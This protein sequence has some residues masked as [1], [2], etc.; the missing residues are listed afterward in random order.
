MSRFTYARALRSVWRCADR[1]VRRVAK[2]VASSRG[3]WHREGVAVN[4]PLSDHAYVCP[5]CRAYFRAAGSCPLCG[6]D[7]VARSDAPLSSAADLHPLLVARPAPHRVLLTV[8]LL[9]VVASVALAIAI[10]AVWDTTLSVV[11]IVW[12]TAASLAVVWASHHRNVDR[13]SGRVVYGGDQ[14]VVQRTATTSMVNPAARCHR[15]AVSLN[16]ASSTFVADGFVVPCVAFR[17]RR[18][19]S[20]RR[21]VCGG[22]GSTPAMDSGGSGVAGVR[23]CSG[24]GRSRR[25]IEAGGFESRGAP[26]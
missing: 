17:V 7:T 16:P 25:S 8:G 4:P 15:A 13:R 23:A 20:R 24:C 1:R 6:A 18:R 2:S 5:V 21:S 22:P 14:P 3:R 11:G 10:W 12:C 9:A 26:L 19:L